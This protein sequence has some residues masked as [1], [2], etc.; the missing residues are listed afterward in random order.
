MF[1]AE[2]LHEY[3]DR[4]ILSWER[5]RYG[6]AA[7][8]NPFSF[9]VWNRREV[10]VGILQDALPKSGPARILELGCGTGGLP[11]R[12]EPSLP[13]EYVGVDFSRNAIERARQRVFSPN[14]RAEFLVEDLTQTT[15]TSHGRFTITVALGFFDWVPDTAMARILRECPSEKMLLSYSLQKNSWKNSLFGFYHRRRRAEGYP[16][17]FERVAI[18]RHLAAAGWEA[19]HEAAGARLGIGRII[20]AKRSR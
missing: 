8:V 16:R 14:L 11:T 7:A 6:F 2:N 15:L 4:K 12:L 5:S 17:L 20:L 3:W 18:A 13:T 9:A 19:E 10:A 1:R